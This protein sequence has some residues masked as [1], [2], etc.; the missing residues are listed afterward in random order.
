MSQIN[1]ADKGNWDNAKVAICVDSKLT[2]GKMENTALVEWKWEKNT[3]WNGYY[4]T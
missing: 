4:V 1:N 3:F 2:L